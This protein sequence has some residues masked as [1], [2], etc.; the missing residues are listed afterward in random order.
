MSYKIRAAD[1]YWK[2]RN[3]GRT[4]KMF[5]GTRLKPLFLITATLL[6]CACGGDAGGGTSGTGGGANAGNEHRRHHDPGRALLGFAL[7]SFLFRLTLGDFLLRFAFGRFLLGLALG[8]FLLSLLFGFLLLILLLKPVRGI[9]A[10]LALHPPAVF[11]FPPEVF[12]ESS[13]VDP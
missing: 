5:P 8:Y 2:P 7:G 12:R 11:G 3:K 9:K 1:T 13:S 6:L 4:M 10:D